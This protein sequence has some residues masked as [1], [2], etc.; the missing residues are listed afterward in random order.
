MKEKKLSAVKN[1]T[2][3]ATTMINLS[4]KVDAKIKE[5]EAR[6]SELERC[7]PF[8]ADQDFLNTR[9]EQLLKL[10]EKIISEVKELSEHYDTLEV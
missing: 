6:L 5:I 7:S 8:I 3:E 4:V 2:L 1:M 9:K 10:K